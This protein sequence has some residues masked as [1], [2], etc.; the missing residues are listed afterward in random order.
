MAA[1]DEHECLFPEEQEEGGR[2]ILAP[3]LTCGVAALEALEFA[4]AALGEAGA[5]APDEN[6]IDFESAEEFAVANANSMRAAGGSHSKESK[7]L[8]LMIDLARM[9]R[10]FG[11]PPRGGL[12]AGGEPCWTCGKDWDDC[13]HGD[14]GESA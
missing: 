3:C 7:S 6:P 11:P 5:C 9:V 13:R 2:L 10:E 12:D 8:F 14:E 4:K 1:N